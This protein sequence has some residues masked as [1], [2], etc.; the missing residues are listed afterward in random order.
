MGEELIGII[1]VKGELGAVERFRVERKL[2]ERFR[3]EGI[4]VYLSID[5]KKNAEEI[6]AETGISEARLLEILNF[7]EGEGI[8]QLKTIYEFELESTVKR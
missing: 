2:H 3:D 6:K 4:K 5:S 1:P 7:M 8:I